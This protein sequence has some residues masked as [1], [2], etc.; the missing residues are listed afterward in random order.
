[1]RDL[2]TG[3]KTVL[4]ERVVKLTKI[5]AEANKNIAELNL[6]KST[7]EKSEYKYIHDPNSGYTDMRMSGVLVGGKTALDILNDDLRDLK[8]QARFLKLDDANI[9]Y[10]KRLV[11]HAPGQWTDRLAQKRQFTDKMTG[12]FFDGIES[13]NKWIEMGYDAMNKQGV[14]TAPDYRHAFES[15]VQEVRQFLATVGDR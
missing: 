4:D 7:S 2:N 3:G 8:L 10:L 9:G 15:K 12:Y 11:A 6:P 5:L 1:M 13:I 14:N